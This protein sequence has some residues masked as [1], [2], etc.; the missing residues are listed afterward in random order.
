MIGRIWPAAQ[1]T[2]GSR[3]GTHNTKSE[4]LRSASNCHS[5]T[6]S[7]NQWWSLSERSVC[8]EM[9][10][11]M[12]GM[13]QMYGRGKHSPVVAVESSPIASVGKSRPLWTSERADTRF[14]GQRVR[15]TGD[16]QRDCAS[17]RQR[18]GGVKWLR[19]PASDAPV[20]RRAPIM[21]SVPTPDGRQRLETVNPRGKLQWRL[22]V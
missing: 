5:D 18:M 22:S 12:D 6:S 17:N 14:V 16:C 1:K 9:I 3:S 7:F 11:D 20:E 10:S 2:L 13:P 19:V 4:K 21:A 15:K 8:S